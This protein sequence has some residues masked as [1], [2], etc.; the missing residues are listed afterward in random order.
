VSQV[1]QLGACFSPAAREHVEARL[2][3][4]KGYEPTLGLLYGVDPERSDGAGSWST[5]AL[6]DETIADL[7]AT[8]ARFGADV[9]FELDGLTVVVA[10]IGHLKQLD[11]GVLELRGNRLWPEQHLA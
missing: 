8:Y 1:R 7:V 3:A 10:Q 11:S 5:V 6:A 4:I 2:G 9:R